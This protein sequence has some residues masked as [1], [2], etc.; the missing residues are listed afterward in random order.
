MRMA[1]FDCVLDCASLSIVLVPLTRGPIERV[2]ICAFSL[3]DRFS[4]QLILIPVVLNVFLPMRS[5]GNILLFILSPKGVVFAFIVYL[6][7]TCMI[8]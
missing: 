4:V 2:C 6:R 1:S 8:F 5:L 3:R 7:I